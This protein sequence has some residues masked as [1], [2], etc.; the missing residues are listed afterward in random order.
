MHHIPYS[1]KYWREDLLHK[2]H[3]ASFNL[4]ILLHFVVSTV[5]MKGL[6]GFKFGD[7]ISSNNIIMIWHKHLYW[8]SHNSSY[9]YHFR[10]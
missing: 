5:V 4:A 2:W 3:L 7:K 8:L 10:V 9:E 6:K 1:E